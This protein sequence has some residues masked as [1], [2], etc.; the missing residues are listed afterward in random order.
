[1]FSLSTDISW[2]LSG[3]PP[4]LCWV[5]WPTYDGPLYRAVVC[6]SSALDGEIRGPTCRADIHRVVFTRDVQSC[7]P[8]PVYRPVCLSAFTP[9]I[10]RGK[11]HSQRNAT[12]RSDIRAIKQQQFRW[13]WVSL[14]V[15]R[16][17]QAFS[18]EIC[19]QHN[20]RHAVHCAVR[21]TSADFLVQ[22]CSNIASCGSRPLPAICWCVTMGTQPCSVRSYKDVCI[23]APRNNNDRSSS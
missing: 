15:I 16:L 18:D 7:R 21:S 3:G 5:L 17:L 6:L 23:I 9:T 4:W 13:P 10:S 8:T 20:D 2:W 19:V 11:S 12:I 1:M 14:K 22:C